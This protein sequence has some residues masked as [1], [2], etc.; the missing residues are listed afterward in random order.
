M[1]S[2]LADKTKVLALTSLIFAY[3]GEWPKVQYFPDYTEISLTPTQIDMTKEVLYN[4]LSRDP[5]RIRI[6]VKPVII[7]VI[8]KM[9]WKEAAMGLGTLFILSKLLGGSKR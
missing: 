9:Y 1:N 2:Y 4:F 3:T 6:N 8:V 5:G 7:P